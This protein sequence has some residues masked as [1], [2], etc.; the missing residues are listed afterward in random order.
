MAVGKQRHFDVLRTVLTLPNPA[1]Q[2]AGQVPDLRDAMQGIRPLERPGQGL[3]RTLPAAAN[4]TAGAPPLVT[5]GNPSP[6]LGGA[7]PS[8]GA[9]PD[10]EQFIRNVIAHA[11]E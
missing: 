1:T 5:P 11:G 9:L 3:N 6:A 7:L 4:P 8:L 10:R 2:R